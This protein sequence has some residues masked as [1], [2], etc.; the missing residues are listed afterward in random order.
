MLKKFPHDEEGE[1]SPRVF[2]KKATAFIGRLF[3]G[4][5]KEDENKLQTLVNAHESKSSMENEN[6]NPSHAEY[7]PN[8]GDVSKPVSPSSAA[9][10]N[11]FI[12]KES[13]PDSDSSSDSSPQS[14][15]AASP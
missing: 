14:S 3:G 12:K 5:E 2:A 10:S 1:S 6:N 7:N 9:Q 13:S 11:S 4:S 8:T 15:S